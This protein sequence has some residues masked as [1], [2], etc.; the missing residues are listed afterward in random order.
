[1]QGGYTGSRWIS[2]RFRIIPGGLDR[3][4]NADSPVSGDNG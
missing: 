3:V 4:V 2:L 1:M